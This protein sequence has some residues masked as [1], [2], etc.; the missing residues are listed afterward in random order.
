MPDAISCRIQ[1]EP[2]SRVDCTLKADREDVKRV[3]VRRVL[4]AFRYRAVSMFQRQKALFRNREPVV[5]FTFDDFPRS[6]LEGGIILKSY[7]ACGTY[8]AA[9]GLMGQISTNGELF[10]LEDLNQLLMEGHELGSHSFS[11]LSCR[12]AH[13]DAFLA[14]VE[15]GG[16]EVKKLTGEFVPQHFS[17]PFGHYNL[18]VIRRINRLFASCRCSVGGINLSPI[19]PHLLRANNLY[20]TTF[21]IGTITHLFRETILMRGW[22]IFYTH[23][24]RETPSRWGCRPNEFEKVVRLAVRMRARI[25]TVGAALKAWGLESAN[26]TFQLGLIFWFAGYFFGSASVYVT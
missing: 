7:G 5:S 19:D 10:C 14:D 4:I 24:V 13:P 20:S 8:Y 2:G 12:S 26:L 22:L 23:D 17:Y 18:K 25:L 1:V 6:A 9:M 21:D 3:R 11:H 16:N 15:K